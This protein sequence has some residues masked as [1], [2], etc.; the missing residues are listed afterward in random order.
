MAKIKVTLQEFLD[1]AWEQ[2]PLDKLPERL[3]QLPEDIIK[4][5]KKTYTIRGKASDRTKKEAHN[6][7][8]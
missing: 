4:E 5:L 8:N 6:E 1:I 7:T 3:G 2:Y